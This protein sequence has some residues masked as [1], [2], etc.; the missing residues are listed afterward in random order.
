[1]KLPSLEP[2]RPARTEHHCAACGK[3]LT[4]DEIKANKLA[5]KIPY[6]GLLLNEIERNR[7]TSEF[8]WKDLKPLIKAF[9]RIEHGHYVGRLQK[10]KEFNAKL[11]YRRIRSLVRWDEVNRL[12]EDYNRQKRPKSKSPKELTTEQFVELVKKSVNVE[13][14]P[15]MT[16][17]DFIKA[18]QTKPVV[19]RSPCWAHPPIDCCYKESCSA[20]RSGKCLGGLNPLLFGDGKPSGGLRTP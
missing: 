13:S 7:G 20:Y 4:T 16:I 5:R 17:E 8:C 10:I 9:T 15:E 3:E 18:V 14:K 2:I 1:M 12:Y 6:F 11:R 19:R